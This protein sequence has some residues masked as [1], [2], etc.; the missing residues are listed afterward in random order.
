MH[1]HPCRGLYV[2]I[3]VV[4]ISRHLTGTSSVIRFYLCDDAVL[5]SCHCV[6]VCL[7]VCVCHMPVLCQNSCTDRVEFFCIHVSLIYAML[8]FR[9]I[10]LSPKIMVLSSGTLCQT[11]DL[12]NF[13][14]AQ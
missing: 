3:A 2:V 8:C 9:E 1:Q 10:R 13:A 12:K 6:S 7:Y 4:L 14:K 11:L 5:V